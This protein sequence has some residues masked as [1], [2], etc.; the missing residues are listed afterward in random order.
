MRLLTSSPTNY[1]SSPPARTNLGLKARI[2]SGFPS[3]GGAAESSPRRE[4]WVNRP[5]QIQA[6]D[7]A[8]ENQRLIPLS[9]HPGLN[10]SANPNPRLKPWA[11]IVRCSAARRAGPQ[12]ACKAWQAFS[13]GLRGLRYPGS[14]STKFFPTLK[15]LYRPPARGLIHPF[16][17]R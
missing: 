2:L 15:G 4:P 5:G 6:P 9:P 17:G 14:S 1:V 7:G 10:A 11:M 12:P 13:P 8:A 3:A 16:Q